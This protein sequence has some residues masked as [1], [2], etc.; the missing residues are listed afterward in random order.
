[1]LPVAPKLLRTISIHYLESNEYVL[2]GEASSSVDDSLHG[3]TLLMQ[4]T[5]NT[6]LQHAT[7]D[8]VDGSDNNTSFL[9]SLKR[10]NNHV[11]RKN[12]RSI[13]MDG[14]LHKVPYGKKMSDDVISEVLP[15]SASATY[16]RYGQKPYIGIAAKRHSTKG[17]WRSHSLTESLESYSHILDSI[18]NSESKRTLTSSKSTRDHSLDGPS[19]FSSLPITCN[20]EFRSQGLTIHD[21][22]LEDALASHG[23]DS[24]ETDVHG[25]KEVGADERSSDEI[26]GGSGNLF[27]SEE[28][29]SDKKYDVAVSTEARSCTGPS[30]SEVVDISKYQAAAYEDDGQSC[31]PI[32]IN[33]CDAHSAPKE[34]DDDDDETQSSVQS[35]SCIPSS[36][37]TTIDEEHTTYSHDNQMHSF[38]DSKPIEGTLCVPDPGHEF[39][40]D[41]SCG[42]ETESPISV[43]DAAFSD[44]PAS[45][46]KRTMLD[47][48]I[49]I[50]HSET[51]CIL[52]ITQ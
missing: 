25:D 45:L 40:A 52:S 29:I 39:E 16:D 41:I 11:K 31:S 19:I 1:M 21:E 4:D 48:E 8:T 42:Q 38:H 35:D 32:E 5:T 27:L 26:T 20:A 28:C 46:I 33:L 3:S 6:D 22:N 15:R 9:L 13:S 37:D 49:Y 17:F 7:S 47:G 50:Y 34:F 43:L 51:L 36:E 18:A 2:D 12:H 14:I 23:N 24:E 30:S 10:E 44:D